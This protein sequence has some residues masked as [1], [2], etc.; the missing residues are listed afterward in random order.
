[1]YD[2]ELEKYL[3][4]KNNNYPF[5]YSVSFILCLMMIVCIY[6]LTIFDYQSYYCYDAISI[7]NMVLISNDTNDVYQIV[8]NNKLIYQG[9]VYQY[10]VLEKEDSN[11]LYIKV[12]GLK[13]QDGKIVIKVVGSKQKL[14]SY[15]TNYFRKEIL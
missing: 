2:L 14:I 5:I 3:I 4:I 1:M 15:L 11:Y 7:D 12:D 9:Y 6:F 10:E 13:E 8:N